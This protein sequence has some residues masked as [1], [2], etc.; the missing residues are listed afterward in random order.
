MVITQGDVYWADL[1]PPVG[2][3]P[4]FRRP[5]VIIQSDYFNRS[6]L[7]TAVCVLLTANIALARMPGNVVLGAS[8]TGLPRD[9]V[10]N[11]TQILTVD[12]LQL[13]EHVG[14]IGPSQLDVI[15]DGLDTVLGR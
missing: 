11:V 15:F 8:V 9:S 6:Q 4:G 5:V 3:G 1:S 2:S 7:R 13:T 14:R 10:A 12:R